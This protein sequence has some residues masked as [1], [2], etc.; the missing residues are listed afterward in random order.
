MTSR[1]RIE[2]FSLRDTLECG[3]FFRFTKAMDTYIVHSSGKTF[4]LFKK[5][6][7]LFYDGVEESFLRNFFRLEENPDA[8]LMEIDHDPMI[9]QA[10]RKYRGLKLIRQDPWECLLSFLCSSAKA[11]PHIRCI[12]ELL[13]KVSGKKIVLGNHLGYA[14]PEPRSIRSALQLEPVGAGFRTDFL[15]EVIRCMDRNQLLSLKGLPYQEAKRRLT[16]L[17]GVGKKVADCVLLYSLD[18]LEAFPIDTWI[19]RGLQK[20]YFGG[21]KIRDKELEAFVSNHFGRYAG[22]AQLYLYHFW[23]NHPPF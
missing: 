18:F 1:I 6:D 23:R 10:I 2:N 22:Y 8:I 20:I 14:F 4:S 5:G 12:L 19:K 21:K 13:C 9:H 3:Q 11:I 16:G 15:V 17:S 7:F